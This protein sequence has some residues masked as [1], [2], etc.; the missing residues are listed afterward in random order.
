MSSIHVFLRLNDITPLFFAGKPLKVLGEL[1]NLAWFSARDNA[2]EG[3]C[4]LYYICNMVMH[5]IQTLRVL[6]P[7]SGDGEGEGSPQSETSQDYVL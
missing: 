6:C 1:V 4:I 3:K 7:H 5:I 2:F